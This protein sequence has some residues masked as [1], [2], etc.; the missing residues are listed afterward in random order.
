LLFA[1]G[2]GHE[3]GLISIPSYPIQI[4][5]ACEFWVGRPGLA[6]VGIPP[7]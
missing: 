3:E 4:R 1:D 2:M 6:V 5:Q 7:L